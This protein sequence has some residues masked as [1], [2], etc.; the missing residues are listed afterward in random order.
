MFGWAASGALAEESKPAEGMSPAEPGA[1]MILSTGDNLF[2]YKWFPIDSQAGMGSSFD[3]FKRHFNVNRIVWRGAQAQWMIQDNIFR[4][5]PMELADIYVME[6]DLETKDRLSHV[7]GD[8]ARKR[9]M[10]YWGYNSFFEVGAQEEAVS[11]AG[12]GPYAFEDGVRAAHP[13]WCLYDRAGIMRGS[14]IEFGYPEVRAAFI[15]KYEELLAPGGEFDIY[16]GIIFYSYVENFFPRVTDQFIYSDVAAAEFKKRYG[17]DVYTEDFDVAKYQEMRG[18]WVTQYIREL[19]AVFNKH[20][21]KL[22]FYIDG[23]DPE[24]PLRWPSYPEILV[25]GTVKQDWRAWVKEGLVDELAIRSATAENVKPFIEAANGTNVQI[26]IL[27]THETPDLKKTAEGLTRH[28]W[29]PEMASDF[30]PG[31]HPASD[32]DNDD[33]F[34]V[35]SVLRQVRDNQ[36]DV[37]VEKITALFKH[38]DIMVRRQAISAVVARRMTEAVP[39]LEE[40]AMDPDNGFRAMAVDGLGT[41]NGPNSLKVIAESISQ[42]PIFQSRLVARTAYTAMMPDRIDDL[43]AV[44]DSFTDPYVRL[45]ITEMVIAK[46]AVPPI[47]ALPKFRRIIAESARQ[48]HEELRSVA[49]FAAAYYPDAEHAQLLI[50]MTDDPSEVVQD[51]AIFSLGEVARRIDDAKLRQV[52]FDRLVHLLERYGQGSTRGDKEWGYRVAAEALLAGYGP[53]GHRY[54]ATVLNG[55]DKVLADLVWRV[56]FQPNDGWNYYPLSIKETEALAAYHPAPPRRIVPRKVYEAPSEIKLI[57]QNF[58]DVTLDPTGKWGSLLSPG[59]RWSAQGSGTRIVADDA[60]GKYMEF[61]VNSQGKGARITADVSWDLPDKRLRNRLRGHFPASPPT[62]SLTSGIVELMVDVRKTGDADAITVALTQGGKTSD[63]SVG[64]AITPNGQVE[65]RGSGDSA[66]LAS[67]PSIS[68]GMWQKFKLQL[69]FN[70]GQ[71]KLISAG[72]DGSDNSLAEFA[73][74]TDGQYRAVVISADGGPNTSSHIG[75]V[76][77]TQ[78]VQ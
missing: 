20:G 6:M 69:D 16:D 50:Q 43:L 24:I 14:T 9:G 7:A 41:V 31:D 21:K 40:A 75:E 17:V 28:I 35:M 4:P 37:P 38:P 78:S 67:A 74:D 76:V 19:R 13:E 46:R 47:E 62:Y 36:L 18:E 42:Y 73:F 71:A 53:V 2:Y 12:F 3:I 34:V 10:A 77:L 32:I 26:S 51:S 39:A 15:K 59:G 29:S 44:Y 72:M 48:D 45:T 22:A 5:E 63:H 70:S 25:P 52:I 56:L 27:S 8:E 64:F 33:P 58:D 61:G 57:A 54:L 60:G 1:A 66:S 68:A 30:P 55:D 65:I 23:N 11:M 49:A